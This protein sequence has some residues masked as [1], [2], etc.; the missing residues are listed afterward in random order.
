[1]T[2]LFKDFSDLFPE[3]NDLQPI[4]QL[5][6]QRLARSQRAGEL[7][8]GAAGLTIKEWLLESLDEHV[9]TLA[10]WLDTYSRSIPTFTMVYKI[11]TG[12]AVHGSFR[13]CFKN[14]ADDGWCCV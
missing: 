12:V 4:Q 13:Q 9:V 3:G 1:M 2:S 7:P 14:V 10:Q 11:S 5:L 6:E 8:L